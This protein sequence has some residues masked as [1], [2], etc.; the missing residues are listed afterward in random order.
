ML[1]GQRGPPAVLRRPPDDGG[2]VDGVTSLAPP[3]AAA[4]AA[5]PAPLVMPSYGASSLDS[6]VPALLQAPGER[7]VWLPGPLGGAPQVVLL[8]LDGLGWRQLQDRCRWAPVLVGLEGGPISSVAPTTTAA[9]LTSLT[10]GM[11]PAAHG[12]VGYKFAVAGPSGPEVLN[13]LRWTTRSGDARPFVPPRQAQPLAAFGG[14]PVPVVSRSDFSG[15]GFSQAHQQGAREVAWTVASS[16]PP[17]VGDLLAQGE[18]FVYA[19]YEGIDK[20]AHAAGL[21]ALY[22]AELAFVDRLVGDVM[23]VLPPGAAL[24]VTSDHGQVDVGSRAR[25]L[26]PP[27]AASTVLVSGE[28]RFR[29]LH[30]RPG[31][32]QDLLERAQ[33]HYG[34]EAWVASRAEVVA[35]GLFG[36]PLRDEFLGRL[37]DVAMVPLGHDAYLDPAD[38]GDARLVCRHG[39]LTADEMFVPLLAA[40]A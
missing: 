18:A 33:A 16:L 5:L 12:I 1:Q 34:G 11:V 6:L 27:V 32:A 28:A 26:A 22:D 19:Y 13:V 24:A 4:P 9:A 31:E 2:R 10:T 14:R 21:G 15:S 25:P 20:V 7:P 35:R 36:G 39:V 23:S 29:W 8:A 30:S 38:G 37:G 17:L 40:G 3:A